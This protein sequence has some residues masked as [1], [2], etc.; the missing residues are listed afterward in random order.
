MKDIY[1]V[2]KQVWDLLD[3]NSKRKF[4]IF[5][6]V[7][8]S[9]IVFDLISVFLLASVGTIVFRLISKESRPT[10]L[11][12]LLQNSLHLNVTMQSLIILIASVAI[13]LIICSN[14]IKAFFYLR[15]TK[16]LSK[17]ETQFAQ[18]LATSFTTTDI[19]NLKLFSQSD[20]TWTANIAT[21]RMVVGV[22][23]PVLNLISD[24]LSSGFLIIS[25]LLI[26]PVTTLSLILIVTISLLIVSKLVAHRSKFYGEMLSNNSRELSEVILSSYR[27]IKELKV[28]N[29]ETEFI[30]KFK[31]LRFSLA[32]WTQMSQW[33]SSLPRYVLEIML[34]ISILLI[35]SIEIIRTDLRHAI[36][37]MVA[38][39]AIGFRIIPAAQR[40]QATNVS[41]Q[42]SKEIIKKY[43]EMINKLLPN[44]KLLPVDY[45]KQ[46][47][48]F[49]KLEFQNV[50]YSAPD[51]S[52]L[53]KNL[54]LA[55]DKNSLTLLVGKSGAGK[56]TTLDLVAGLI[57]PTT[58]IIKVIDK[59][60][61]IM[62]VQNNCAYVSQEP[63]VIAGSFYDNML[64]SEE[65][66]ISVD[67]QKFSEYISILS[68]DEIGSTKQEHKV[69][70]SNIDLHENNIN[71]RT[72]SGGEKQRISILRA[73]LS[74]RNL[75]IMDEPTSALDEKNKKVVFEIIQNLKKN[76][77]LLI[78]S[79]DQKFLDIADKV[80][81]L[82]KGTITFQGTVEQFQ[83]KLLEQA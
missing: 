76:R 66:I 47:S 69:K 7:I 1:K 24:L 75:V 20:F 61:N 13:S 45:E 51:S 10:R 60:N 4:Y 21:N 5:T 64:L 80:I 36:T 19:D 71:S 32:K 22:L 57:S 16:F 6:A 37:I 42:I 18:S 15:M 54:N 55:I 12:I 28:Y 78:S 79:H 26:S 29:F 82:D 58:G 23:V 50:S 27:G 52:E 73:V 77:C 46:A 14:I 3:Q 67:N 9:L 83:N 63:F 62:S 17:I 56:T 34:V 33:L 43:Y 25:L 11:E 48:T 39:L 8:S 70:L 65:K 74:D 68:L 81:E 35:T 72:L 59:N 41:I 30:N 2:F 31:K 40:L 49:E 38:Y 53:L 44:S